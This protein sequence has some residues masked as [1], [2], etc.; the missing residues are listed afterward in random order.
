MTSPST[1]AFFME[2]SMAEASIN[3]APSLLTK[4]R[5]GGYQ[6]DRYPMVRGSDAPQ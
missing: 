1:K 2:I 6:E 3:M 5:I 4:E